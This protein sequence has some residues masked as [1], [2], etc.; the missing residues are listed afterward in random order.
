LR[1][2]LIYYFHQKAKKAAKHL[3]CYQLIHNTVTYYAESHSQLTFV[4]KL[5]YNC[6][7][8]LCYG[9]FHP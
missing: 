4:I 9:R 2:L 3:L 5:H 7:L 1:S 8:S 6:F